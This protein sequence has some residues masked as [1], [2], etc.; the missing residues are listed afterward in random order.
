[1]AVESGGEDRERGSGVRSHEYLETW[2]LWNCRLTARLN[3]DGRGTVRDGL[4]QI[5]VAVGK[6]AGYSHEQRSRF[7]L[8][9]VVGYAQDFGGS[10]R[11]DGSARNQGGKVGQSLEEG[12]DR[13]R[14]VLAASGF[15]MQPPIPMLARDLKSFPTTW[16]KRLAYGRDPRAISLSGIR[17]PG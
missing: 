11:K 14:S 13:V 12:A 7:R 9:G 1:M 4:R 16:A 15:R 5:F 3:G 6:L 17:R 8:P 2:R 10:R